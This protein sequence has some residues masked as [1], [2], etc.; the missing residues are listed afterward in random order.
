MNGRMWSHDSIRITDGFWKQKQQLNRDVT[1][2]AVHDRFEETGR[3]EAFKL[4][5][6]EG[7]PN[8]PHIFWDS[9]IAKWMESAAYLLQEQPDATLERIMDEVV[10]DIARGRTEDGYF[11]SYYLTCEPEARFTV[12]KNHELYCLGHL[13]EAAVAY[14]KAT[15]KRRLLDM[16]CDYLEL[17]DRL[18][19]QEGATAF[20]SPGHEE[21]ELA[22]VRLYD[23]TG[24]EKYL[25]M[26]QMF[27]DRRGDRNGWGH[28]EFR[29]YHQDHLP[30]REQTEAKGHAVRAMYLYSAMADIALR[31]KEAA[32]AE[33][34]RKLFFNVT[35][36]KMYLTGGLG[37]ERHTE[38]FGENYRL[39]HDVAYAETCANLS[40]ALFARRMSLLDNNAAYAD[41]VERVLYNSFLSGLSLSGDHFFY[42]NAQEID[43][44]AR[45]LAKD[46]DSKLYYAPE[47]RV[48]VFGCSCCPPNV[49]R[50]IA[51]VGDFIYHYGDNAVYVDQY[52]DSVARED[53]L[54]ITQKTQ[55]PL[56]G[57]VT[58]TVSGKSTRMGLRI[59]SWCDS[60]TLRQNGKEIDAPVEMGYAML[61]VADGDVL[62]LTLAMK[63]RLMR[64]NSKIRD[65]RGKAAWTYGPF[66]MCMEGVDN[67]E[68]LGDVSFLRGEAEV[69]MDNTLSLPTLF[70]PAIREEFD[71]LYVTE[72][73][74]TPLRARLIP[75]LTFA[76]RGS[77]DMFIWAP[78][79]AL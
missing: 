21:I 60:Y 38:G 74:A 11:N 41:A 36:Q 46:A 3:F 75:Y 17:V 10:E 28:D 33:T 53:G 73:K 13:I 19:A 64:A 30:V 65:L 34:C 15:G 16:M 63:P 50:I 59:P 1:I 66:V 6:K 67:G 57:T 14:D 69:V 2:H 70:V 72:A 4:K 51:T 22:L 44:R 9:D 20:D 26:S 12:R 5:W 45:T 24:N 54:C 18:F 39:P 7:D 43:L 78:L 31:T 71:G 76:N 52:I 58:V 37:T 48:K 35:E 23:H 29:A 77:T 32:L 55:Y 40:L 79:A 47:Q 61:T 49:T 25:R 42:A 8:K 27:V 56:D 62:T 68:D